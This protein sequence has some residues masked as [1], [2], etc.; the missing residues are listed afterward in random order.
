MTKFIKYFSIM[1]CVFVL[2]GCGNEENKKN[3]ELPTD[4]ANN[5][6]LDTKGSSAVCT[7]E[8]DYSD[9]DGFVTGSKMVIYA[10]E[11]GIV[12]KIVT[13]EKVFS[14]D[15]SI[16]E[17]LK[18]GIERNYSASSQYGGYQYEVVIDGNELTSNATLDYTKM[19]LKSMAN[20][21]EDLKVYLNDD[22]Q[23]TLSSVKSM[24]MSAGAE[25]N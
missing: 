9:I 1:I 19:D 22:F 24:Y 15:E 16:L 7:A 21:I 17:T 25:C 3:K 14:Y 20:D 11:N 6:E 5:I 13:Q 18:E 12:T 2:V 8:Y 23:Y 10:D 4:I